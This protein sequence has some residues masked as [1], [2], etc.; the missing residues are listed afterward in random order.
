[1]TYVDK[2]GKKLFIH[3]G[4]GIVMKRIN[5]NH[6]KL[7]VDVYCALYY[8]VSVCSTFCSTFGVLVAGFMRCL[9]HFCAL[10]SFSAPFYLYH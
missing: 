2:L 7:V 4:T 6:S 1:M 5:Q 3:Q 10:V 9:Y 8:L